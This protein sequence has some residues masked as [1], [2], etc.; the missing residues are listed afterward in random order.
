MPYFILHPANI[1]PYLYLIQKIK[2]Y[3][4]G[5]PLV[6]DD[7]SSGALN[8]VFLVTSAQ[9]PNAA[10]IV[11]QA[12]PYIRSSEGKHPLTKERMLFEIQAFQ[13]Y[14]KNTPAF[15]PRTYHT[16]EEMSVIIME[17]LK[18][19]TL[20]KEGL[21]NS[22]IYPK[23]ADQ[24][25]SFL[26]ENLFRTSSLYLSSHQKRA[27]I[28]RFNKNSQLC[29]FTEDVVFS[30]PEDNKNTAS[31]TELGDELYQ[32]EHF[33]NLLIQKNILFLKYK[34]MTQNDALLHGDFCGGAILLDENNTCIFDP[35][36]SFVGPF[37]YDIGSLFYTLI[38]SYT[39]HKLQ[40][41][42]Y[43]NWIFETIENFYQLFEQKFCLIWSGQ[44][45]TKRG[46]FG[47][48]DN[49]TMETFR[50][51]FMKQVLQDSIGFAGVRI[52]CRTKSE[53]P[54]IRNHNMTIHFYRNL[55]KIFQKLM[56]SI[57]KTFLNNCQSIKSI[58]DVMKI[59]RFSSRP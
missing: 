8:A 32:N 14:G 15:I 30:W 47:K 58:Q 21:M 35:E 37:G 16:D 2:D 55:D 17:Y 25:S 28:D 36:F 56:T 12:L 39:A 13:E 51:I 11:K 52:Y 44:D 33:N 23:F 54:V 50:K 4:N 45:T 41:S 3:F 24:I 19:H 26:S 57:A 5:A 40:N 9:D 10:L 46:S 53:M 18:A 6:I 38:A 31:R 42:S 22:I 59:I 27:L 49:E 20:L 43:A 34:F 7:I 29:R 1:Q 48:I